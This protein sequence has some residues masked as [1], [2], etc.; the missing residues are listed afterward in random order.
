MS[1]RIRELEQQ[2]DS[3]EKQLRLFQRISRSMVRDVNT[4]AALKNAV[5]LMV[6]FMR[7]DSCLLYLVHDDRLILCASNDEHSKAVGQVS[8]KLDEGLTGWVAR[9]RRLLAISREA[10]S[11]ARFKYFKDLPQDTFEAFLSAPIIWRNRVVGVINVQHR[12]PHAHSGGE[13]EMITTVGEQIGCM[14]MLSQISGTDSVNR[15]ADLVL[16]SST[17]R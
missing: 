15:L 11:D 5:A 10:Y 7:C 4:H 2:L 16:E 9:E 13:L 3:A 8:L 1:S 6:E 14:L 12:A 17:P